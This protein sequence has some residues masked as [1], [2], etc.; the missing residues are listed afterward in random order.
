MQEPIDFFRH[1]L[2]RDELASLA[3]TVDSLFLTLGPRVG[4][5]ER[6]FG[7]QLG[8]EHV[9]GVSSCSM[10][11]VL[12][13]RGL[14]VGPGSEVIMTPMTFVATANAVLHLGAHPVLVDIE[15]ATGLIDPSAVAA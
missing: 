6:A 2:G 3:K 15:P 9:V 12:A 14:G 4:E 5:F 1:A 7:E 8:V 13:L 11:L 10:G